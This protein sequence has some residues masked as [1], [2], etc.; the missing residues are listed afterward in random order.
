MSEF[1]S[2]E[3]PF[4]SGEVDSQLHSALI[5]SITA[6]FNHGY[7]EYLTRLLSA[8]PLELRREILAFIVAHTDLKPD[9]TRVLV[10]GA[11]VFDKQS[12]LEDAKRTPINFK[13][14]VTSRKK[15]KDSPT[16]IYLMATLLKMEKQLN[17]GKLIPENVQ[18]EKLFREFLTKIRTDRRTRNAAAA[19]FWLDD[20][21]ATC[22]VKTLS[23]GLPSLGKHAK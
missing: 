3:R 8:T 4:W 5:D 12:A 17:A 20:Q 21:E 1:Q 6:Y 22:S 10:K 9:P 15:S 7:S 23:G 19:G 14:S 18:I 16:N 2:N 13:N 11:R